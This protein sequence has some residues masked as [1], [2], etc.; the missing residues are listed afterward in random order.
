MLPA[1]EQGTVGATASRSSTAS[2]RGMLSARVRRAGAEARR[3]VPRRRR[4]PRPVRAHARRTATLDARVSRK[5]ASSAARSAVRRSRARRRGSGSRRPSSTGR[6]RRCCGATSG[7]SPRRTTSS[8]PTLRRRVRPELPRAASRFP[9]ST[10]EYALHQRFLPEITLDEVNALA[11]EW[12]PDRTAWSSSAAPEKPGLVVPDEAKLAAVIEAAR[13]QGRSRPYVDTVSDAALLD[14]LP[15]PGTI[16]KTD[17]QRR[18]S[19][20]TEWELSNGVKV[21]LK[22]TTFK[23]DEILFRATSPGGTSLAS[24]ADFIPAQHGGAGHRR[25]RPRQVQHD[26][27]AEDA[28]RQGR[29]GERR[30][31]ASSK[32]D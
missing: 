7:W 21:V 2:S 1:R 29:V 24:D 17:D 26:R 6:S 25:R 23:E 10:Y 20:I 14:A 4:R 31:S 12:F 11:K 28:D 22:P 5:T 13:R 30:S 18:R 27:P 19:G 16:A 3:A 32:K 15:T 9:A 8:R